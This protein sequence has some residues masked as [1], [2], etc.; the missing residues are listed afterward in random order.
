MERSLHNLS[1][2]GQVPEELMVNE[3][4][5]GFAG[6]FSSLQSSS[7]MPSFTS[8]SQA[9]AD[10]ALAR[11]L[12]QQERAYLLLQIGNEGSDYDASGSGS[13]DYA[14]YEE[15]IEEEDPLEVPSGQPQVDIIFSRG[16]HQE[17]ENAE[18]QEEI[19]GSYFEN[20]EAFA[21][22]LQEAE[23]RDATAYMMSLIGVEESHRDDED[24]SH[25]S[26]EAWQD[27]DPDN[28]SY[29]ELVA[30]GEAVGTQSKGLKPNVIAALPYSTFSHENTTAEDPC[31]ICRFEY[32]DGDVLSTLPCKHHYHADCIKNWLQ[33]NKVCPIC[34]AEVTL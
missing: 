6:D 27:V 29:E 16:S 9:D 26:Q 2:G 34:S 32:E 3:M 25:E 17:N 14:Y 30:L 19:N 12:Q 24:E 33:I 20:D 22:A 8:L 10:L 21:R 31:V 28:M 1:D 15:G 23:Q 5:D 7:S 18:E 11:A 4:L 13:F